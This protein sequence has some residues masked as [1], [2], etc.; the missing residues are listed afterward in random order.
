[1]V[2]CSAVDWGKEAGCGRIVW[3]KRRPEERREGNP[4]HS[5]CFISSRF[6]VEKGISDFVESN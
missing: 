2:C 5:I 6:P 4:P 3:G 1:M